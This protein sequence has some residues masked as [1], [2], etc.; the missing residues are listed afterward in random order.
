ME[1]SE[2]SGATTAESSPKGYELKALC[3]QYYKELGIK[4]RN[5]WLS[6]S[7]EADLLKRTSLAH[8]TAI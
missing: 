8:S 7:P 3:I 5:V 1:H 4:L 6:L 2:L